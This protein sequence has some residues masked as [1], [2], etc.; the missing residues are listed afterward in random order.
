MKT[1]FRF[2]S[3]AFLLFTTLAY[4]QWVQQTLP[5][6]IDVT[7]GIDFI[8]QNKGVMGGWHFNFGG[9][10][11]GN[12]FYSND[13]GTNWNESTFPDSL[14]II[15]GVQ[16]INDDLAYG[17]GAYNKTTTLPSLN[18][19]FNQNLDP[20]IRKYYE[21]MGIDFSGQEDYRGYFVETSDG[22]I[23]WHPKGIFEDSVYYLVGIH[24][25]DVQT[26]FVLATGPYNNTFAAILKTTD[27]GNN[28]DYVYEFDAYLFL[29][30]IKFINQLNGIAVGT[31]DDMVNSYG[32]VLRTTDGGNNW[33]KTEV[34]QLISLNSITYISSTSILISGV[35]NDF[36]AVIYRSDDGGIS[37]FECCVY[38]SLHFITGINSLPGTGVI[39][40][41]G[42]YQPPG[43]AIP[44]IEVTLDGGLTWYYSLL[45]EFPDYF[46][47]KSELVDESRWYLTGTQN[48]QIGIVL[49]TDNSGGVPVELTS[50]SAEFVEYQVNLNWTTASELNNLGFEVERKTVN[51]EWRTIG[52]VNGK[53]N[54][55]EINDYSFTDDLYE[56]NSSILYY[57]L[58]QIDFNGSFEYSNIIEVEVNV[59][60]NFSL[61]QNYP[62]PFNPATTIRYE[63]PERR[64]V[65]IKVYDVLG[66]EVSTL[67][68]EE[69]A[70]GSYEIKIDGN[71]LTSGIYFY[72]LKAGSFVE[73]KKMILVK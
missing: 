4:S 2:Q 21:H 47:T 26:G 11:F 13:A 53:G 49:F 40:I 67:V 1:L 62:N 18:S 45:S 27:G 10:I 36:T 34:P 68:D 66:N 52:F 28:W 61:S 30:E 57:R 50:F 31:F 39:I 46:I 5:G 17:A 15:A 54:S 73:T 7:L 23:S 9:Q 55:T 41:Y 24:F 33:I 6:D 22:G 63:I 56:V 70:S 3:I 14:R 60:S 64:F 32:V 65:T 51:E 59:V 38:S 8:N 69:K 48:A 37:W 19:N 35:R 16:M 72:Q 12:A 71:E 58:K 29:N 44:F 25:L 42:K 20:G 43:S